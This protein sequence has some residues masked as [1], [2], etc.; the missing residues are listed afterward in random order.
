MIVEKMDVMRVN[1]IS[2]EVTLARAINLCIQ[3]VVIG[4]EMRIK[5]AYTDLR[6][7]MMLL[8]IGVPVSLV[9][10]SLMYQYLKEFGLTIQEMKSVR[11]SQRYVFGPSKRYLSKTLIE[12]PLLIIRLDG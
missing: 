12:L 8:D 1:E 11:C 5:Y 6:R 10:V 4:E 2:T 3:D 7:I 9:G